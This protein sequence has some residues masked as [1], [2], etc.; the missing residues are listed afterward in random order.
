MAAV[1]VRA[2]SHDLP[3]VV[4]H[5]S[6]TGTWPATLNLLAQVE[7]GVPPDPGPAATAS[8]DALDPLE[9]ERAALAGMDL[10]NVPVAARRR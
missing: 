5:L 8:L 4:L 6:P 7:I 10:E 1:D 2:V 3:R 9:V